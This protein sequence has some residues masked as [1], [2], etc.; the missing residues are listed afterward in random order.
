MSGRSR[1]LRISVRAV[2]WVAASLL[3]APG[4]LH[5]GATGAGSPAGVRAALQDFLVRQAGVEGAEAFVANARASDMPPGEI[6]RIVPEGRIRSGRA[7]PFLFFVR[8]SG[9]DLVGVRVTADVSLQLPVVH[10]ARSLSAGTVLG[11]GDLEIRNREISG[12]GEEFLHRLPAALGKRIRWR[13]TAGVPI[14]REYLEDPAFL[15]RGET[16]TIVAESG[17]VRITGKGVSLQSGRPGETVRVRNMASG[18]EV[19]G[20]LSGDHLVVVE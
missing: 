14:R 12:D 19:A 9:G 11:E 8:R 16:V 15:K 1:R 5:A 3:A 4:G 20:R 18:R 7:V 13:L 6:V 17:S 2:L 10:S